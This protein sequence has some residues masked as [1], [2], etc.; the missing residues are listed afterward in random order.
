MR[1]YT[2]LLVACEYGKHEI[3]EYLTKDEDLKSLVDVRA[4]CHRNA[5]GEGPSGLHLAAVHNVKRVAE[6]LIEADCPLDAVDNYV[7][8]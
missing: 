5:E 7:C 2:P 4:S 6:L 8:A 3:V 1:G